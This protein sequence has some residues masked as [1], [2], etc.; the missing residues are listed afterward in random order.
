MGN[1]LAVLATQKK[2]AMKRARLWQGVLAG[3]PPGTSAQLEA[4]VALL[5]WVNNARAA[6]KK[7][8]ALQILA[9]ETSK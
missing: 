9:K 3:I 5:H 6:N 7:L 4:H 8:V 1:R 2:W